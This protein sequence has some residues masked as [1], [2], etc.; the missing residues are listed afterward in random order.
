MEQG[1]ELPGKLLGFGGA[2]LPREWYTDGSDGGCLPAST[3]EEKNPGLS[4]HKAPGSQIS[5]AAR[6]RR[7]GSP[8]MP[9]LEDDEDAKAVKQDDGDIPP[10]VQKV[11]VFMYQ[12]ALTKRIGHHLLLVERFSRCLPEVLPGQRRAVYWVPAEAG[13]GKRRA[14]ARTLGPLPD[15]P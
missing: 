1:W 5:V 8:A 6:R 2:W 13:H 9:S 11:C 4:K 3:H 10:I 12:A 14:H 15:L 7:A